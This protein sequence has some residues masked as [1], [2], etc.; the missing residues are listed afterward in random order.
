MLPFL[1]LGQTVHEIPFASA[2]NTIEL[3]VQNASALNQEVV[4]VKVGGVPSW[5]RFVKSEQ[6]INRLG[7]NE[8]KTAIF[9]FSV[10]KTAP[11]NTER[12]LSFNV[13][14]PTNQDWI[15][16]I[17]VKVVPPEYFE[18]FQNFP[19]PFNP[20]TTIAYQLPQKGLV[21][22]KVFNLIGQTLLTLS[23]AERS[24]GYHQEIWDA[25]RHSSGTYV[26]E[27]TVRFSDGKETVARKKMM[28][29]Q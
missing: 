19:N 3:T 14:G 12:T 20:V 28:V 17:A 6:L 2:N 5:I 27:L 8:E 18:L 23:D 21:T 15:K 11:V 13:S 7:G 26:Y 22:L 10:D 16:T 24:A 4:K 9:A 29:V 25:S 1:A